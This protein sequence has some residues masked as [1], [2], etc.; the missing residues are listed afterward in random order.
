MLT[1]T[2]VHITVYTLRTLTLAVGHKSLMTLSILFTTSLLIASS[3]GRGDMKLKK[4]M[5]SS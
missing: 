2:H 1:Q 4:S 5:I 3:S